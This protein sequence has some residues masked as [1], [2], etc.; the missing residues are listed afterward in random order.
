MKTKDLINV[1]IFT[2]LYLIVFFAVAMTGYIPILMLLLPFTGPLA[3]GIVYMLF[4]TKVESF[5]MIT[6]MGIILSLFIS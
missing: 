4:L 1:G 3:A 6:I 5:G 2:A